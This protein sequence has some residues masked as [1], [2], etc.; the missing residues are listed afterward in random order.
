MKH[1][2]SSRHRGA[3]TSRQCG[4]FTP[5]QCGAF[6]PR[7]RGAFTS[8]QCEAF[9]LIE[10]LVVIAIIA[11]LA[12]ILFPVFAQAREKARQTSCASNMKQLGLGIIQYTQD[13][14]ETYPVAVDGN[15]QWSNCSTT[16]PTSHWEQKVLPYIKA[17]GVFGCPDDPGAGAV[18]QANSWKG[19]VE[20]YAVNGNIGYPASTGY[21]QA[22]IGVMGI[23]GW[24]LTT[25]NYSAAPLSQIGRPSDTILMGEKYN[26]DLAVAKK[27]ESGNWSNYGDSDVFVGVTWTGDNVPLPNGTLAPAAYPGGAFGGVSAHHA[28]GTVANFVFCDGHVKAMSPAATNPDPSKQWQSNLWDAT[29][30]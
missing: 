13:Y 16:D 29:R 2:R 10:L 8:R 19:V 14:D 18:D 17:I 22:L 4:A 25:A 9:T 20:S 5:R 6:T 30:N 12:A 23:D 24:G 27:G 3:F 11:I 28:G 7:Q 26:S 1:C 21:K 15:C